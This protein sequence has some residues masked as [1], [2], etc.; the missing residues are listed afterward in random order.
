MPIPFLGSPLSA[1]R[2]VCYPPSSPGTLVCWV[3]PR[4]LPAPLAE[5]ASPLITEAA[6]IL[7]WT[8]YPG[9]NRTH[10]H[11]PAVTMLPAVDNCRSSEQLSIPKIDSN[12]HR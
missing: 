8:V 5:S 12:C 2:N 1:S 7:E 3:Y 11:D 10:A 6:A 9:R 4:A